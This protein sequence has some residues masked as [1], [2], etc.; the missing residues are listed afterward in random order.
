MGPFKGVRRLGSLLK[1]VYTSSNQV[2]GRSYYL[3][4]NKAAMQTAL[5]YH[6][7]YY[8]GHS[9]QDKMLF[10]KIGKHPNF[11]VYRRS[12]LLWPPVHRIVV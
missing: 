4:N 2:P 10:V 6:F 1:I 3:I 9:K 12:Y 8:G 7:Y 11:C 5:S